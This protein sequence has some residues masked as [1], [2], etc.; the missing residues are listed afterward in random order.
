MLVDPKNRNRL[1]DRVIEIL[2]HPVIA[3]SQADALRYRCTKRLDWSNVSMSYSALLH[4]VM[5]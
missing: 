2:Q 1:S 3:R 4:N 5:P